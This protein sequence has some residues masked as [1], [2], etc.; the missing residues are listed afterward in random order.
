MG[1]QA[2]DDRIE[3]FR[4]MVFNVMIS[5]VDDHLRN[6]GFLMVSRHGWM[7]SPVYDLNPTPQDLK[8]RVLTTAIDFEDGT[9][10]V[11]LVLQVAPLFGLSQTLAKQIV[12]HIAHVT[13]RWRHVAK[14]VGARSAEIQRM[15]SAFEHDDL[16]KALQL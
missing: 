9:C 1:S 4:R 14:K 10:S 3:L 12:S 7:L 13:E 2:H 8:S 16:T 5:N 11:D 15:Q 6:H